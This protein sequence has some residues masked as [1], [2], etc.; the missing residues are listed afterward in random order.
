MSAREIEEHAGYVRDTAKLEAYERALAEVVRPG[1]SVL[2]LGSGTGVLGLLAA[3]AG[4]R[5]VY[6]VDS[7]SII[8]VAADI[9]ARNDLDQRIVHIRET[10][11]RL[12]LPEPVDVVVCDQIGGAVYDAGVL[13]YFDDARRRLLRPEAVLVPGSF[14]LLAAP[15]SAG[16]WHEIVE[17][18]S[19]RPAGFDMEAMAELAVNTEYRPRLGAE[20]FLGQP[21]EWGSI[22]SDHVEPVTGSARLTIERPGVLNG[23]A[24][25]FIAQLSPSVELT[26]CPLLPHSFDRWQNFYPLPEAVEVAEGDSVEVRFDIRPKSYLATWTVG[27]HRRCRPDD[28]IHSRQSTVLGKLLTPDDIAAADGSAVPRLTPLVE[29]DRFILGLVD[30]VRTERS[31]VEQ[32]WTEHGSL[33]CSR[34]EVESRVR[35]LTARHARSVPPWPT[36]PTA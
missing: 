33:F 23:I 9:A 27:V 35:N 12:R 8:G 16:L 13:D 26:N 21:A 1:D 19:T 10:S 28:P 31:I 7:G 4:A 11:S 6:A 22:P 30:G 5:I 18:W 17:V 32:T 34:Q 29:A 15:V 3:R 36:S 14:R 25:M 24:G 2:D 20:H